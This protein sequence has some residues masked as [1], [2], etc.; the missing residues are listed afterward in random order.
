MSFLRTFL[1]LG[2]VAGLPTIWSNCLAGWWLG[3]RDNV[4]KLPILFLGATFLYLGG[5]F[6]NDAFDASY[7]RQH[8]HGYP[9]PSGTVSLEFVR[10]LGLAW[11]AL[12]CIC[13]LQFGSVTSSLAIVLVLCI[14]LFNAIH[15]LLTFSPAL[16][17]ICRVVL[18]MAA[19]ST[20]SNSV[21]GWSIWC[22]LALGAYV[23]GLE[24][25]AHRGKSPNSVQYWPALLLVAPVLLALIMDVDGY[26]EGALL[27]SAVLCLWLL[28]CLRHT[29]W[30]AER[31]VKLTASGL[32][33]GIVLIDWL[34]VVDAPRQL[35]FVFLGLWGAALL[36][37]RLAPQN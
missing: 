13:W 1:K 10:G 15:R 25:C 7:D 2:R 34:A 32:V 23:V 33:A 4:E 27:V 30:S 14:L 3:G 20:A 17:A 29:W 21:T 8:R 28:R 19:A 37:A 9:I 12:G 16:L 6:L 35:G 24:Y 36:L 11:L 5:T 22:G 26:R 31:N 18:Y